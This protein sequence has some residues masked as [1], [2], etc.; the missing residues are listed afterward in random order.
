MAWLHEKAAVEGK[1]LRKKESPEGDD[2]IWTVADV[3]RLIPQS[4]E[5]VVARR[6]AHERWRQ[7]TDV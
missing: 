3:Y 5:W 6:K 1:Q 7:V 2:R 4:E